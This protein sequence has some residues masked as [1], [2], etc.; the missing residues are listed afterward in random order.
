M[1]KLFVI[2]LSLFINIENCLSSETQLTGPEIQ[3]LLSDTV[4]YADAERR[5]VRQIFNNSGAT[6][7]I[8][9]GGQ[10]QGTWKVQ[11]D[12]YCSTWPPNSAWSCYKMTRDGDV[13]VFISKDGSRFEMSLTK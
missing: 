3:S 10:S 2:G 13:V 1:K 7:I 12:E 8:S 11:A 5:P 9:A 4:L 6:F